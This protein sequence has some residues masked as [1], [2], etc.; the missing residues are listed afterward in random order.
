MEN[1]PALRRD[2]RDARVGG[3][4]AALA[5]SWGVDP[6]L[7][8]I[9]TIILLIVTSGLAA[10]GYLALWLLIPQ[11][12]SDT[13]PIR[14]WLPFTRNLSDTQLV[15]A[16]VAISTAL[17]AVMTGVA[18]G[19]LIVLSVVVI[20][21]ASGSH[22]PKRQPP[23]P[24]PMVRVAEPP[25]TEF[26]RLARAWED[27][28][29]VVYTGMPLNPVSFTAPATPAKPP[30]RSGRVWF[31]VAAGFGVVWAILQ[32][33]AMRGVAVPPLAYA[34]GFLAVLGIALLA[35]VRRPRR[36][37][38][39]ATAA[40]LTGLATAIMLPGPQFIDRV[41][42]ESTT[43]V[44]TNESELPDV[45]ELGF[46]HSVVNLSDLSLAGDRSMLLAGEVG[47]VTVILPREVNASVRSSIDMGR[48]AH[49]METTS[50]LD[51]EMTMQHRVK[52][53]SPNLNIDIRLEVGEIEV[54]S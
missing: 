46:G 16:V 25:R 24:V 7:V 39:L 36:P 54:L 34:S 29:S 38:G 18:P 33:V 14:R 9:G 45:V 3:V 27:R 43:M 20:I 10:A 44:V 49:G 4:C 5:R 28:V 32:F 40:V 8:R 1:A 13:M 21:I 48:I 2:R 26:E 22:K 31:G 51:R 35:S 15:V 42:P 6:K 47:S 19:G 52:P 23:R 41:I 11:V 53:G 12:G 37:F 30:S 50:G 17:A